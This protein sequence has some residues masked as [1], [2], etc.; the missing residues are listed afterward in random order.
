MNR[1]SMNLFKYRMLMTNQ[2]I[3]QHIKLHEKGELTLWQDRNLT[4]Q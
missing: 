1:M 3:N 2:T 4:Y